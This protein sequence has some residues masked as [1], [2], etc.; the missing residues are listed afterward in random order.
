MGNSHSSALGQCLTSAVGG[1]SA[2]VALPSKLLYQI[3]DV[4][5][6][7]LDIPITP[8]AVTYPQT[9]NH[10]SAILK[11][12]AEANLKVQARSGGHS[13]GNYG[14]QIYFYMGILSNILQGIGG[15]NGAIV[16]DVKNFQQFSMDTKTWVATVG[17]GTLLKDL[18]TR[19]VDNG[20][21]AIAH[22]TCPQVGIGGHATIGG[23]GP[24]SR[25][26]G[27]ALDHVI[28]A[29]VVLAN[30]TVVV[31]SDTQNQEVFFAIKGAAASFG[32]VTEF[33]FRTHPAPGEAVIY[34]YHFTFGSATEQAQTFK[35]WQKLISDPG[36]SRE[37]ASEV[38]IMPG[39]LI[40]T[41]TYFGT[42][43]QYNALDIPSQLGEPTVSN[44]TVTTD[45]LGTVANWAESEALEVVGGVSSA[46]Y[47]K[48]LSFKPTQLIPDSGIND[49]FNYLATTNAGTLLWF[50]IFDLESGAINDVPMNAT[51]YGHRDTLFY[52][53]SY[54]VDLGFSVSDTTT[55][56]L[57][58]INELLIKSL[59]GDDLG[60]YAGYVDPKLSNAQEAYLGPN[61]PAL[62]QIKRQI[63]PTD[64]FHN[65]QSVPL[66]S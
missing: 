4:K 58:G 60:A 13:Y 40:I 47:S 37:F 57:D 55:T 41:G 30:G 24:A 59:P 14:V 46:F 18:T 31:A 66:A 42:M 6:Y 19:M 5:A 39:V 49:L 38:V 33:K 62:K 52:L 29:T 48:S 7:N 2:L 15:A 8:A 63:D 54:A 16:I 17:S 3:T 35:N 26:W 36:L 23:L 53:Q 12:A 34:S 27:A 32:I 25:M 65:P 45:W 9:N 22:G 43:D 56:F 61:L 51:G 50:V 20:N 10:I 44:A 21:R 1:N 28:E 64:I 11:C